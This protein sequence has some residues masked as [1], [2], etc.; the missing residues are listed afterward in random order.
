MKHDSK[1]ASKTI[2]YYNAAAANF[3][4]TPTEFL[5]WNALVFVCSHTEGI[6]NHFYA[7]SI[8]DIIRTLKMPRET[9]RRAFMSLHKKGLAKRLGDRWMFQTAS[10][11]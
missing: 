2:V 3:Q 7:A 11:Q 10:T 6:G 8:A 4:L 5:V 9:I 1:Y